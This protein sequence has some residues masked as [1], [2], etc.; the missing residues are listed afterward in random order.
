MPKSVKQ[1]VPKEEKVLN[2]AKQQQQKKTG[3]V[4]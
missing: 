3:N 2:P 1:P 4:Y